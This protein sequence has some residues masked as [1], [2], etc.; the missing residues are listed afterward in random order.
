MRLGTITPPQWVGW[1]LASSSGCKPPAKAVGVQIPPGPP[2]EASIRGLHRDEEGWAVLTVIARYRT[3]P[4]AGDAVAAILAKHVAATRAEQ[5]C[6]QFDACRSHDDPDEFGNYEK[7]LDEKAFETHRRTAHFATYIEGQTIPLLLERTWQRY[8]D[9]A[10]QPPQDS[11]SGWP[12][13]TRPST[14]QRNMRLG[15]SVI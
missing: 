11:R 3:Q 1:A 15:L 9:L 13:V 12:C 4:G 7:Y 10:P 14:D 2:P 5:G 6:V 8:E